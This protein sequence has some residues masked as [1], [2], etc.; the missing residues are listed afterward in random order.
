MST[1]SI[2]RATPNT[3]FQHSNTAKPYHLLSSSKHRPGWGC[4]SVVKPLPSMCKASIPST[5]KT[6]T[7]HRLSSYSVLSMVPESDEKMV[8][9]AQN[10]WNESCQARSAKVKLFPTC[11]TKLLYCYSL[12]FFEALLGASAMWMSS[13]SAHDWYEQLGHLTLHFTEVKIS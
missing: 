3:F 12:P 8:V 6:K 11:S 1:Q 13:F 10:K 7:P 5:A 4:S 2:H 9:L